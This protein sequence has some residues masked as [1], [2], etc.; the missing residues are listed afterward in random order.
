[1]SVLVRVA[2]H[3][4]DIRFYCINETIRVYKLHLRKTP[5]MYDY[6]EALYPLLTKNSKIKVRIG[7][8]TK[9]VSMIRKYNNPI[10]QTNQRHREEEP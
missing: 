6:F 7:I 1:M 5:F 4:R 8:L 3:G 9:I 2:T 10:L